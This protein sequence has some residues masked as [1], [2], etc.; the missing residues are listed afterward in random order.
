MPGPSIVGEIIE[1]LTDGPVT[2][3]DLAS[4][5]RA[6]QSTLSRALRNLEREGRVLRIGKTRGAR[7]ALRRPVG[8]VGSTWGLYRIDANGV[9]Q[10]TGQVHAIARERYVTQSDLPR[11]EGLFRG[12]P[13][14]LQDAR[15]AGFLGRA[16]PAA[17]PELELPPRVA[18]WNDEH[19]LVFL[20]Q[21]GSDSCGNLLL[22]RDAL[23]LFLAGAQRPPVLARNERAR[24]YP[25]LADAAMSGAPPG[26]S[27]QG[28]NPK[29]AAYLAAGSTF[30]QMLVK[31]SPPRSTPAGQRWADLLTAEHVAHKLLQRHGIA[32]C[33]SSLLDYGDRVFLECA[34]FDR[35]G[36]S[37][38][39]GAVS[40]FAVDASRYGRLDN[41]SSAAERLAA[42]ALL[43]TE[44]A[45]RL[46]LLDA[47]GALIANT[48]RHFGNV[49]LLDDHS[50]PY[51]LAPVYDMLPMMF[52]PQN[53]QIVTRTFEPP[54]P[55]A[56]WIDVW[57]GALALAV[58]YWESLAD[59]MRL[60]AGFRTLCK[61]SRRALASLPKFD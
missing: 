25:V 44:Q 1:R 34:R 8:G 58:E 21:R 43:P 36:A 48:D 56:A 20:T 9:P 5:L 11:I 26:S 59:D 55:N 7:Y 50:G 4:A 49:T 23:N 30:T 52:A 24:R 2:S 40:L 47:F 22:G 18:D 10:E 46:Q 57:S 33:E 3:A 38:R 45:Q 13:Y 54:P 37:G 28:E 35:V 27:A 31:F 42:D 15:P 17:F 12:L 41:W 32:A 29:F 51:R 61:Q 6:S 53:E 14:Y 60:T 39:I 16:I 19:V